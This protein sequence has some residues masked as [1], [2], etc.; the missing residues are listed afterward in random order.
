MPQKF[1]HLNCFFTCGMTASNLDT[2]WSIV[3]AVGGWT[4]APNVNASLV[5][6][7]RSLMAFA[8]VQLFD[9][10]IAVHGDGEVEE[11]HRGEGH[12]RSS[13]PDQGRVDVRG[14]GPSAD[15]EY[16]APERVQVRGGHAAGE[17]TIQ[18]QEF[19]RH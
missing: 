1:L 8:S 17:E 11:L 13:G 19:L 12:Q 7:R 16:D 3:F 9:F 15:R 18:V 5:R 14:A 2:F 6:A 4:R 10:T